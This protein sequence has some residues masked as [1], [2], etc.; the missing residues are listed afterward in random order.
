MTVR[1]I[2]DKTRWH[3]EHYEELQ[4][5]GYFHDKHELYKDITDFLYLAEKLS[6]TFGFRDVSPTEPVIRQF[7]YDEFLK[8]MEDL[9]EGQIDFMK[10]SIE[11]FQQNM[12]GSWKGLAAPNAKEKDDKPPPD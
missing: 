10:K 8:K 12:D 1:E 5:S 11:A 2:W 7:T 6:W 9:L 3:T 4:D